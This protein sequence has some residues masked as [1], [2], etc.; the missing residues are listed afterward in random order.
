MPK[1]TLALT[2]PRDKASPSQP[3]APRRTLLDLRVSAGLS[4]AAI[5]LRGFLKANPDAS[6]SDCV[7]A[8][9]VCATFAI[10]EV[11]DHVAVEGVRDVLNEVRKR[12]IAG[13]RH[14]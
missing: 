10:Y 4:V 11:P 2:T 13:G 8:A 14:E 9:R 3:P 12:Q 5:F 7:R 6:L 1:A